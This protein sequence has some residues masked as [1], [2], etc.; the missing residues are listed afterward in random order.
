MNNKIMWHINPSLKKKVR[1]VSV[2]R[3]QKSDNKLK[4]D[5]YKF[6]Y[7]GEPPQKTIKLRT[8]NSKLS[9]LTPEIFPKTQKIINP[10]LKTMES[11]R[12]IT[13]CYK[14]KKRH[15][16][17]EKTEENLDFFKETLKIKA[18]S[19]KKINNAEFFIEQLISV[20]IAERKPSDRKIRGHSPSVYPNP[21]S[22][23]EFLTPAKKQSQKVFRIRNPNI[24]IKTENLVVYCDPFTIDDTDSPSPVFRPRYL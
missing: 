17:R 5:P 15:F 22:K 24:A 13:P 14:L 3:L 6:L 7:F 20:P 18:K 21:V 16:Q 8:D 11:S 19:Q 10:V 4:I 23:V 12:K 1:S 9:I 2:N